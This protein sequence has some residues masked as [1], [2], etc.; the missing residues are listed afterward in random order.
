MRAR[1][2]IAQVADIIARGARRGRRRACGAYTA[3]FGRRR[4]W[5]TLRVSAAEFRA[6]RA[7]LTARRSPRWSGRSTMSTRF[8]EAQRSCAPVGG[9]HA[10]RA[11][12]AHHP[13]RSPASACMCR[14]GSAPLP[15][16]AI[17]LA[18][19]ARIA[20]C[21]QRAIASSPDADGARACRGAGRRGNLRRRH[22]VQDGR[23]AG[24]R[25][26]RLRHRAA[27]ARSTRFSGPAVPG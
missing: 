20:G 3:K 25:R 19:P 13:R 22:R 7:R 23:R 27:S 2:Y 21:P 9:N 11:L 12:R 17:M 14:P 4:R 6:A 5:A 16:T 10:G 24:H 8:H 26:A 18:A 1:R 15:S